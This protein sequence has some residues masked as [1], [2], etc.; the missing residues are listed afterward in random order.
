M[1]RISIK[2]IAN[3]AGVSISTVSFVLNKKAAEM[4]ISIDVEENVK[5]IATEMGYQPN[6]LA[7]GLRTGKTRT[8]GLIVEDISNSFF[9]AF[10]KIVETHA[11]KYNYRVIY[12]STDKSAERAHELVSTLTGA[13]VDGFIIVPAMNMEEDILQLQ[14]LE[15]PV[16]LFDRYLPEINTTCVMMDNKK[17]SADA[18]QFLIEKGYKKIAFITH[19]THLIQIE[20]R[21]NG[22]RETLINNGLEI[23]DNHILTLRLSEDEHKVHIKTVEHFMENNPDIDAI[24]FVN[25][26]LGIIGIAAI[27]RMGKK[28]PDDVAIICFDDKDV[29]KL[30]S[31]AISV[32]E[33]PIAA[34]GTK[35]VDMLI[36]TLENKKPLPEAHIIEE[37]KLVIRDSQ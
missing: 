26:L 10:A 14:R 12:C 9:S 36:Q 23:N 4:R 19:N 35:T 17:A 33:Q 22:Y 8:I 15:I 18:T 31:P 27:R 20:N 16:V 32:I 2:D 37:G 25:N 1:N 7:R 21:V 28:I 11:R 24:I 5:K 29:F 30:N 6:T 13:H 34:M 3:K